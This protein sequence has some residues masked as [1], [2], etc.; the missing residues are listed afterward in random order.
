[1]L[2]PPLS[3][4]PPPPGFFLPSS[5]LPFLLPL[6]LL[7]A[8]LQTK[9]GQKPGGRTV[10]MGWGGIRSGESLPLPNT[11]TAKGTGPCAPE[12]WTTHHPGREPLE[13][14][15]GK[16]KGGPG[17]H[18][19]KRW[20]VGGVEL[21]GTRGRTWLWTSTCSPDQ[22]WGGRRCRVGVEGGGGLSGLTSLASFHVHDPSLPTSA[23]WK[24]TGPG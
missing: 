15:V 17:T 4:F 14:G 13:A 8:T 16:V 19:V 24:K 11:T 10:W 12:L 2:P 18:S 1:M 20:R 6:S 5:P 7:F 3:H 9:S 23:L 22:V 21:A